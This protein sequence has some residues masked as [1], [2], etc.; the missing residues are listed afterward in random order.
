MGRLWSHSVESP[1]IEMEMPQV[2]VEAHSEPSISSAQ[3]VDEGLSE[4][5]K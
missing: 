4:F 3:H 2:T 5:E 1:E